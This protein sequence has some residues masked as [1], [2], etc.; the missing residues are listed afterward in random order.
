VLLVPE[1]MFG[2]LCMGAVP[3]VEAVELELVEVVVVVA[4]VARPTEP[5]IAMTRTAAI[6]A[7][8]AALLS[9]WY[10][11]PIDF[12]PRSCDCPRK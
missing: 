12:H 3:D 9:N 6:A 10:V 5:S 4:A 11:G 1:F 2:Q 7:Y 8:M